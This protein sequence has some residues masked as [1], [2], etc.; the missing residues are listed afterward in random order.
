MVRANEEFGKF[1]TTTSFAVRPVTNQNLTVQFC[2][3][4]INFVASTKIL[5]TYK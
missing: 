2:S 4:N 3:Y 1:E 5:L